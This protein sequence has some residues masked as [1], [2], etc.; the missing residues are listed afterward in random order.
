LAGVAAEGIVGA[1]S[2]RRFDHIGIVVAELAAGRELLSDLMD[3]SHWTE[4]FEDAGIGVLVQFARGE[5]GPCYELIAPFGDASPIAGSLRGGR[6]ILNHVAYLVT[7]LDA[8]AVRM[9]EQGCIATGA[10]QPAVAYGGHRVQF[11]MSPLRFL[12]ELIE[13]PDHEHRY[14]AMGEA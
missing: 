6:N 8:E 9:L 5:T 13:A 4:V 3:V 12:V 2:T 7:D 11:W 1:V 10:A 14:V